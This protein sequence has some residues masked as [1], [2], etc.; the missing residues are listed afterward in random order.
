MVYTDHKA[1]IGKT[2]LT[3][4]SKRTVRLWL[5][6][7][8]FDVMIKHKAGTEMAA[9]DALSRHVA[10]AAMTDIHCTEIME[11]HV[12]LEHRSW[13]ATYEVLKRSR[14]LQWMRQEI[15]RLVRACPTCIQYKILATKIGS[16]LTPIETTAP[17]QMLCIDNLGPLE[18]SSENYRYCSVGIAHLSTAAT[19][20]P[21]VV[22]NY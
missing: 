15:W 3:A 9:A 16:K 17:K 12:E 10:C 7:A 14:S 13:K 19:A 2:K 6:L 18:I 4:D 21:I 1:L 20:T 22:I 11:C 5:E 8:G